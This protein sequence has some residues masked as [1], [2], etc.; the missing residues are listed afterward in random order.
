MKYQSSFLQATV[1]DISVMLLDYITKRNLIT[2]ES[3]IIAN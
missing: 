2:L 3:R 1:V